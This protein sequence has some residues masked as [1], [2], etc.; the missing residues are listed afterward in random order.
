MFIKSESIKLS[1]CMAT[2]NRGKFIGETLDSILTQMDSRVELVV[3][4]GASPDNTPEVMAQY[5]SRYP[6]IRYYREQTNSGVDADYDKAVGYA[7]G[8]YCWLMTD[9]DLLRPGAISRVLTELQGGQDL[10]VVNAQIRN[11]D[12]SEIFQE[13]LFKTCS[14]KQYDLR[15]GESFFSEMTESLSFIGCVVIKRKLWLSRNRELYFGSLFV[16]VGVIFQQPLLSKIST[17]SERLIAIR[18]GNAMWTSRSFEIWMFL[19]PQLVW[20]FTGVSEHAKAHVCPRE[21]WRSINKLIHFR[22]TGAYTLLEYQAFLSNRG[23]VLFRLIAY[24]IALTPGALLN[25]L[26]I[27]FLL[28]CRPSSKM[29]LSDALRSRY[30]TAAGHTAARLLG[31]KTK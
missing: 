9:D 27:L 17:V 22:V 14:D 5:L 23:S 1:I 18:Y 30:S 24:V 10:V 31:V 29:G 28:T 3:V 25:L 16:H 11:A 19:W 20:S 4:D 2:F 6:E 12:L 21:A 15:D 26:A 8:E 7:K 13:S